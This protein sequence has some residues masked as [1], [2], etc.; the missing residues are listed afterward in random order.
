M[1]SERARE[2]FAEALAGHPFN[3]VDSLA[4][5]VTQGAAY[6]WSGAASDVFTRI[7]MAERICEMGPIAG[8]LE[9]MLSDGLPAIEGWAVENGCKQMFAQ[10]GRLGLARVMEKHGYRVAGV[11]L[12]KDL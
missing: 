3:T 4:E 8:D 2:G 11:I 12:V 7:H 1:I 6:V 9:E 5:E 10:A